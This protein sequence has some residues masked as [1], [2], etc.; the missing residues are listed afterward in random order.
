MNFRDIKSIL[1]AGACAAAGVFG[2]NGGAS[3]Q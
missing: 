1:V 2:L 3:A